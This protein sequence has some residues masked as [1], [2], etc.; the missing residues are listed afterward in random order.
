MSEPHEPDLN[1]GKCSLAYPV[2]DHCP[3]PAC[4]DFRNI[5]LRNVLVVDPL[6]TPGVLLGNVSNPMQIA[7][8]NV[9]VLSSEEWMGQW[10]W[11]GGYN[12]ANVHGTCTNGCDPLPEGFTEI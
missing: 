1:S 6:M 10:P 9:T 11:E 12:V 5:T 2:V 3:V 7:F 4:A 8:D